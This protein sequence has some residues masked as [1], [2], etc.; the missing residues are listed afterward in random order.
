MKR[1]QL[2]DALRNIW[3]QK[4]SFLSVI[5]IAF[6]G[7]TTFLG[8]NFSDGALR[9]NGSLMYNAVNY[10]DL[11]LISTSAFSPDDL[12]AIRGRARYVK[13]EQR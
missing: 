4:V 12:D 1:T 8:I 11:E 13:I 9:K 6:L 7:V 5:V 10:R 2:K 3:K